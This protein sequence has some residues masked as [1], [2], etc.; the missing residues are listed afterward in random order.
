MRLTSHVRFGGGPSEK[1]LVSVTSLAAYP[2]ARRVREAVRG[3][4]PVERPGPR[5]GPTSR[6]VFGRCGLRRQCAE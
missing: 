4:G 5:P 6:F 3:N 1:D 2:T